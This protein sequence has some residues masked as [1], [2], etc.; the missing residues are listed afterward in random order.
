MYCME[1]RSGKYS[2]ESRRG[3]VIIWSLGERKVLYGV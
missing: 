2:M 3:E 1:S